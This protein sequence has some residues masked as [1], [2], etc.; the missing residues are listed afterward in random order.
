MKKSPDEGRF[1]R[2][3]ST[4]NEYIRQVPDPDPLQLAHLEGEE[5]EQELV[6]FS[7]LA[8]TPSAHGP[9]TTVR[10][11]AA[12]GPSPLVSGSVFSSALP[13]RGAPPA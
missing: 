4:I 3:P 1:V 7:L 6:R 10:L 2:H 8:L 9:E 11:V 13:E 12:A 5:L